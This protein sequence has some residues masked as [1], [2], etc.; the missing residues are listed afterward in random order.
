[1]LAERNMGELDN[2]IF[3]KKGFTMPKRYQTAGSIILLC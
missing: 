1:M 2:W 3:E